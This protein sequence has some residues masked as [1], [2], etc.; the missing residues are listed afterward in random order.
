MNLNIKPTILKT[1]SRLL[2]EQITNGNCL[3]ATKI[4]DNGNILEWHFADG[5]VI[6]IVNNVD[7]ATGLAIVPTTSICHWSGEECLSERM[8]INE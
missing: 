3:V 2:C 8:F 5:D 6:E 4:R 7:Y 1:A